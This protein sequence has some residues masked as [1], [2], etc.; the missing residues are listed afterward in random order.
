MKCIFTG[1]IAREQ[2]A[3][4]LL[5]FIHRIREWAR[6]EHR[7]FVIKHLYKWN[8]YYESLSTCGEQKIK[9]DLKVGEDPKV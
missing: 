2:D 4:A 5:S 7:C 1:D 6:T 8:K 9:Q 3:W